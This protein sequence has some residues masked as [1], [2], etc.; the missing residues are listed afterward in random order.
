MTARI[1]VGF[2]PE[3]RDAHGFKVRTR[4]R[5][6]LGLEVR[7][8]ATIDVYTVDMDISPD[9][10][11]LLAGGPYSDAVTQVFSVAAP[12]AAD[13][14]WIAEVGYKPGVTDNAGRTAL[15]AASLCLG[16]SP[17]PGEKVY[18]SRQYLFRGELSRQDV[19]RIVTQI[20]AN[21]LIQ[22]HV[23]ASREEFYRAGGLSLPVPR[24]SGSEKAVVEEIDIQLSD[25]ALVQLSRERLL[26]LSLD[27]MRTIKDYFARA[28]VQ[29]V[30][31]QFGLSTSQPMPKS[32]PLGKRGP[33]TA[34]IK[35]LMHV[36][37][38]TDENGRRETI[39]SLFSTCIKGST[40]AIRD[41]LGSRDWCVSVFKD[42]AGVITW[43][44]DV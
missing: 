26:A 15:E 38:Y 16:R 41:R 31:A 33:S 39:H 11:L 40:Q 9:E 44:D 43:D 35:Y 21:D 7:E 23:L 14:E 24:V 3:V 42:N 22:R 10:V 1:E 17:S 30:R 36:I 5:E 25:D 12:L 29:A 13:F 20:L 2:K 32:R 8:V 4:I 34:S 18:T 37:D 27:E 6:E 28:D 19:E